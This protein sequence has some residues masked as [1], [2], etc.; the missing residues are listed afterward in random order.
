MTEQNQHFWY[1]GTFE[2]VIQGTS[3]GDARVVGDPLGAEHRA[4]TLVAKRDP[5]RPL[6][7]S[8]MI[9]CGVMDGNY[10]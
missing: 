4:E 8:Q 3:F 5:S 7:D 10:E 9:R 2:A 1:C 6:F